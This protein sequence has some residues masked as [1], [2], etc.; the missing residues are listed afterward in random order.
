MQFILFFQITM[1]TPFE[2]PDT[3]PN[4]TYINHG[5]PFN[6][7]NNNVFEIRT[8]IRLLMEKFTKDV[9]NLAR[10]FYNVP[11]IKEIYNKR[12]EFDLV[13]FDWSANE[14]NI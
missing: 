13:V 10:N 9:P 7:Q 6:L 4:I 2:A 1:I 11:I 14:V 8:D 5:L 12:K 3:N